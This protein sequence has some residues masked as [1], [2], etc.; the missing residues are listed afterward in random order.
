MWR[1]LVRPAILQARFA[2]IPESPGFSRGEYVNLKLP[3][4]NDSVETIEQLVES[5][6]KI[7][8]QKVVQSVDSVTRGDNTYSVLLSCGI[9]KIVASRLL[10]K[11]NEKRI[12]NNIEYVKQCK[13]IKKIRCLSSQSHRRRLLFH[14][15]Y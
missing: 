4:M 7:K 13:N 3:D 2:N 15:K 11:Y 12:W 5:N 14:E 10:K 8:I 6:Q 1:E 9:G